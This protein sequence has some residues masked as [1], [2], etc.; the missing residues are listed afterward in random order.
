VVERFRDMHLRELD[1]LIESQRRQIPK[2]SIAGNFKL[3]AHHL[4]FQ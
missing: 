2:F 1:T 4:K 3:D